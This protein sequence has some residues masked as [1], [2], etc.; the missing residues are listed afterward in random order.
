[1]SCR[2]GYSVRL[3]IVNDYRKCV[4]QQ[5]VTVSRF[6][7]QITSICTL[8]AISAKTTWF[9]RSNL[10]CTIRLKKYFGPKPW[11]QTIL[12]ILQEYLPRQST[13][14]TGFFWRRNLESVHV[15]FSFYEK[16]R[17]LWKSQR[18][19][20]QKKIKNQKFFKKVKKYFCTLDDKHHAD[21]RKNGILVY[22]IHKT[23]AQFR[24]C[25]FS[26]NPWSTEKA[27]FQ[28]VTMQSCSPA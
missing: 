13:N 27:N 17:F 9:W 8:Y 14:F 23:C 4:S 15:L 25:R 24:T 1:M 21:G 10:T 20:I 28:S 11:W 26:R 2:T 12:A 22:W 5:Q 6:R 16:T 18:F 19:A 3:Y 7:L